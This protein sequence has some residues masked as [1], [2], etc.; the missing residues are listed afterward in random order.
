MKT[1]DTAAACFII[2]KLTVNVV[3][4]NTKY[5]AKLFL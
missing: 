3:S 1:I 4:K 2:F 5:I